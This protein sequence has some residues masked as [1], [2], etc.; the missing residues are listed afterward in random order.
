MI[1]NGVIVLAV[2]IGVVVALAIAIP[3]LLN[4]QNLLKQVG[5][6]RRTVAPSNVWLMF[7]PLFSVVYAFILY[8]KI[9]ESVRAEYDFRGLPPKGDYAK[10]IGITMAVLGVV[11]L[12]PTIGSS[13][14]LLDN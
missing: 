4:L 1:S 8:P 5:G 14:D 10:G 2:I 3:Y 11:G 9:S 7:I 13:E 6:T 12:I